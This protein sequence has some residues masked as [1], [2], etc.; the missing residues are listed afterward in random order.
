MGEFL[1]IQVNEYYGFLDLFVETGEDEQEIRDK[2]ERNDC[3]TFVF[4]FNDEL[5]EKLKK[6]KV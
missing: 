3:E 2:Y 5:R 6:L 4:E 1:V